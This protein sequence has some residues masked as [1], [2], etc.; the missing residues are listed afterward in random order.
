MSNCPKV[1]IFVRDMGTLQIELYPKLAPKTVENF[2]ELVTKKAYSDAI[3]HRVIKNFMVQAGD[4]ITAKS[5]VGE[6]AAN[7]YIKNTL[8]H[9]RGVI[10]MAR[11]NDPNSASAQFFI[12]QKDAPHL[13]NKYA[14][15]GKVVSG[16]KI[17]DLI[18]STVTNQ[19][20][21][22]LKDIVIEKIELLS[23]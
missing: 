17:V 5:I 3:F 20:D 2:I 11:T 13:D 12:V 15:F 14:A 18:A 4:G 1:N 6:F 8:K 19:S 21:R 16:I 23:E 22:P 10:S 7:G 9:E